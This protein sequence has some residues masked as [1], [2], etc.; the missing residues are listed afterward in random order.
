MNPTQPIGRIQRQSSHHGGHRGSRSFFSVLSPWWIFSSR[1]EK[2]LAISSTRHFRL[3]R[4]HSS[5]RNLLRKLGRC[6]L[7][8]SPTL[9]LEKGKK[10]ESK[11]LQNEA[12]KSNIINKTPRKI[13]QNEAKRSENK[14]KLGLAKSFGINPP[15]LEWLRLSNSKRNSFPA[16]PTWRISAIETA[17]RMATA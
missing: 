15:L 10:K 7:C 12:T 16:G 4:G 14:A 8:T 1:P 3:G 13:G 5:L 11:I 9:T 2:N 6:S 17:R